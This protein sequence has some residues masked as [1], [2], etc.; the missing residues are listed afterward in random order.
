MRRTLREEF[1]NSLS[2]MRGIGFFTDITAMNEDKN[3]SHE[4]LK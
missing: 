4:D 1:L 3:I 2:S